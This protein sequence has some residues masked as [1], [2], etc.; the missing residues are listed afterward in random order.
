MVGGWALFSDAIRKNP[1]FQ[2]GKVKIVSV[3]ALPE[4]LP[5]IEEG[6]ASKLLAQRIYGWGY[7]TVEILLDHVAFD[8][9]PPD[10]RDVS[11]LMPVT[12]ETL[13]EY[14]KLWETRWKLN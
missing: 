7:R 2:D 4:S 14:K 5:Y 13:P 6:I 1:A 10:G 8:K 3:D 12:P 9:T 11:D